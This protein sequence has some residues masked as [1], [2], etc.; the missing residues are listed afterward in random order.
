MPSGSQPAPPHPDHEISDEQCLTVRGGPWIPVSQTK[1]E[2]A[3]SIHGS[4]C[5]PKAERVEGCHA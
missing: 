5:Q 3:R 4:A 1:M 2:E